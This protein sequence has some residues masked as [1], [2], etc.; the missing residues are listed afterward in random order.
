M[1]IARAAA[2]ACLML[3]GV[4]GSARAQVVN[5]GTLGSTGA[6]LV[7]HAPNAGG[8]VDYFLTPADGAQVGSNLFHSLSRL[9]LGSAD[10]AVYQGDFSIHNLITRITGGRSS[11]DGSVR[12]EIP[13]ANL[14]LI[15]PD[16][17]VFGEHASLNVSG[18]TVVSTA[19]E[20]QLG[21]SGRFDTRGAGG[22]I[23]TVDPPSSF[24]FVQPPAPIVLN[25]SQIRGADLHSLALIGGD[26]ELSGARS[27]GQPG[28][29]EARGGRIDLASVGS[30]GSVRIVEGATPDLVLEGERGDIALT[31][32]FVVS[33]SG[34]AR[35][36]LAFGLKPVPG[37][38]PI[39]VRAN[40]LLVQDSEI[41]VLTV[42]NQSAGDVSIDLTGDLTQRATGAQRSLI[43]SGS[44]LT[45]PVPPDQTATQV[46]RQIDA[47]IGLIRDFAICGSV[48]C[49]VTY[50]TPAAAGDISISARNATLENG[51]QIVSRS[52]FLADAGNIT[53]D[54]RGDATVQGVAGDGSRS[55]V[56]SNAVGS[57]DQ[58]R[59]ALH[60]GGLLMMADHGVIV[61]ENGE[62]STAASAPGRIE[63]EAASLDMSG[64]ARIDSSTRGAGDGG[65]LALDISG[66]ARLRGATNSEEFTGITTLSQP[67]STGDAGRIDFS[68]HSLKILDGAQISARPVGT[69][70]LGDAGSIHVDVAD[71]LVMRHGAITAESA[72]A[73]GGNIDVA[74]GDIADLRDSKITTSVTQ[75]TSTGGNVQLA[76][77]STAV[78]LQNS[79]IVARADQ[80]FGG[81]VLISTEALLQDVDSLISASSNV[82]GRSGTEVIESPQG[83]I[84]VEPNVLPVPPIDVSSLLR[85]T[86]SMR[87]P[88][89]ASTF[90]VAS[91]PG[92]R[93]L[94]GDLLPAFLSGALPKDDADTQEGASA[95]GP[96]CRR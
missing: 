14:F 66:P 32:D 87:N 19:H 79:Q 25:G 92:P 37:S 38:G 30:S 56:F 10:A 53:L 51:G 1:T 17:I 36:P 75:G 22:D 57:G 11:I 47:S 88:G 89:D 91:D 65:D 94:E 73:G 64:N 4:P 72:V 83:Q 55:G 71:D 2:I 78:V 39:F 84:N 41:R 28:L 76:P 6:G 96:T 12:S 74:I 82:I 86:C 50:L 21:T 63:I 5:D 81:S 18:N 35:D 95:P 27:D 59:I 9:D 69:G 7:G 15:N 52:E 60:A 29:L 31:D 44:G 20:V 43:N 13:G 16:G 42:T 93:V 40:D 62:A 68:A 48:I 33:S 67:G 45:I 54:L 61:I 49:G 77:R 46:F 58:G 80:G 8:G 24:G 34:V 90:V 70:A 85:E 26:L 3:P 23:L